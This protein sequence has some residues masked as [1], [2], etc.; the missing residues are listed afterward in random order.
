MA[1]EIRELDYNNIGDVGECDGSFDVD[2]E[3]RLMAV[4]GVIGYEIV[5]VPPYCKRYHHGDEH[6]LLAYI[7]N[8][9]RGGFLAYLDGR[10]AGWMLVSVNWNNYAVVEDIEVD[11]SCRRSGVGR[12]LIERGREWAMS[13]GLPGLMLETQ[14]NNIAA[15]RFYERCGFILGG[16]DR[17]LYRGE[18][19]GTTEVAMF[20]Y[21]VW[22]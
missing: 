5:P 6:D 18:S 17:Y 12:A 21:L 16:F 1:I 4:D 11:R 10:I 7:G 9:P 13:R 3:L 2:A 19:P 22:K 15:C 14:N 20:W 8:S